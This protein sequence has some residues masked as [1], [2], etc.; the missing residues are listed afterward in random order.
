MTKTSIIRMVSG[1]AVAAMVAGVVGVATTKSAKEE[2][3]KTVCEKALEDNSHPDNNVEEVDIFTAA[4]K[5]THSYDYV[6]YTLEIP[7]DADNIVFVYNEGDNR[8]AMEA[9]KSE[10]SYITSPQGEVDPE[11]KSEEKATADAYAYS[12]DGCAVLVRYDAPYDCEKIFAVKG[13]EIAVI[14][15]YKK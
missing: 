11:F 13:E 2:P 9:T 3:T 1:I 10:K 14:W 8:V 7:Q 6:Y 15:E 5:L 12:Y 4:D